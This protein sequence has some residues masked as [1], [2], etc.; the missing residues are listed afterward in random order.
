MKEL[1]D[2]FA[3]IGTAGKIELGRSALWANYR[4]SMTGE[5]WNET[6]GKG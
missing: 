5:E 6:V 2:N 1:L 4:N 3:A